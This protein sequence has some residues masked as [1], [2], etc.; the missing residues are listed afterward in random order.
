MDSSRRDAK[1]G[2]IEP[3]HAGLISWEK[4]EPGLGKAVP[5][6]RRLP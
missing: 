6:E 5:G 2:A 3:N 1:T 4:L